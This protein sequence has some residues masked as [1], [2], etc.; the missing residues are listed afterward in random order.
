MR[1]EADWLA[2][3]HTQAVLRMLSE[4][5]HQAWT[6]GG[7]VRNALLGEPVADI[8]IATEAHPEEVTRLADAAGLKP[9]PTGIDHGTVT[10][11]SAG[12]PHEVTTFRADVETDG[13]RA[14]V[15]YS[16][17]IATDAARRDFTMNA[18]YADAEGEIADPLGEGL[19]DLRARRVRFIGDPARRIEEDALRILRFFRFSTW[20]GAGP[21]D[22]EG[23]AAARAARGQLARLSRERIGAEM[24][25]LLG[26][27]DPA[28]VVAA[29][30]EAGILDAVL[31]G[32]DAAGLPALIATERA[33]DVS[34]AWPRRLAALGDADWTDSLRLSRVRARH[35]AHVGRARAE[36]MPDHE[37]AYRYGAEVATD[38]ALLRAA[39]AGTAPPAGWREAI[40]EGAAAEF[41]VSGADLKGIVPPGPGM[42]KLLQR[43]ETAWIDSRFRLSRAALLDL[44]AEKGAPPPAA[45]GGSP[46]DI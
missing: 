11:I 37:A 25:R 45:D 8:D 18:L 27:P 33:A 41:P 21:L 23:L 43:L 22:A 3:P 20:Y 29:M 32:A 42:G 34:P 24:A 28:E 30:A 19:A 4:A 16:D 6:V 36:R 15:R 13:R 31:P 14:V 5:G 10:V 17:D 9:V 40:A 46:R 39:A 2:A 12:H 38:A 1:L 26:A 44:A 7:C 35:L